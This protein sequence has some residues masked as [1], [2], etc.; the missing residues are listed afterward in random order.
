[1]Q[2]LNRDLPARGVT[3]FGLDALLV[4]GSIV[5]AGLVHGSFHEGTTAAARVAVVT[6][7]FALV[8]YYHELYDFTA[9]RS[10]T[11]R[12]ARVLQSA[13]AT[14][15]LLAGLA[16]VLPSFGFGSAP[17]LTALA[18]LLVAVPA[19]RLV[20][21]R[22]TRDPGFHERVLILGSGA[23]ARSIAENIESQA[24]FP[25]DV[26][27]FVAD[28][29]GGA[30]SDPAVLGTIDTLP[31]IVRAHQVDRIVVSVADRRGT[32]P[33]EMLLQARLAG[34][35]IEEAT[36]TYERLTGKVAVE[37]IRPSWLIF[38]DGFGVARGAGFLKRAFDL[39]VGAVGLVL[40]APLMAL[41]ALAIR[42]E[43]PGPILYCQERVGQHDRPF[44]LCKF[45][46]MRTDAESSGPVWATSGDDRVTRVGR[47][48]RKTRLDELPQLWNVLRGDMSVVGPRPERPFFVEQLAREIPFYET[49]HA[50]RP[51]V[52][53]WAQ[54]RYQYGAS[55]EDAREK[56]RYD[57]Y[58]IKHRSFGFDLAILID[59]VKVV[60]FGKGAR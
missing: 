24:D 44:T 4:A 34:V 43:S 27:G 21:D 26:V 60:L 23:R 52:T 19:G 39:V 54:V 30:P 29:T 53:G 6:G 14:T 50:V 46:S 25:Y 7:L 40:A 55:V 22:V 3:V 1:M 15:I 45:R 28:G 41:T 59:T 48:I 20:V 57:L 18:L 31:E 17:M 11:E 16:A 12:L 33:V 42:L 58:Y 37:S 8:F 47:F 38:A 2:L 32:L 13:G 35:S 9:V 49:R 10:A 51:G 56:L 5:T 36:A